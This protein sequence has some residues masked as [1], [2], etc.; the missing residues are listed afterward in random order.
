VSPGSVPGPNGQLQAPHIAVQVLARGLLLAF[1]TR[2]Y[3]PH[4]PA[5]AADPVLGCVPA[6]RRATLIAAEVAGRPRTLQW[7]IHLQGERETVCFDF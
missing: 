3:F 2:M 5:N 1:R 4:D 6:A 7:D